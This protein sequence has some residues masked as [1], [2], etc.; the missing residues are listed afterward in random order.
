MTAA[1]RQPSA[2]IGL[3]V[4]CYT[5]V[6]LCAVALVG[7]LAGA[8]VALTGLGA[9]VRDL[10]DLAV[11]RESWQ[12]GSLPDVFLT[13]ARIAGAV[14][15]GAAMSPWLGR[16]C[17]RRLVDCFL[18]ALLIVNAALVGAAVSAYGRA[19]AVALL[20]HLALETF[21]F[22]LA[23]GAYLSSRDQSLRPP[24]LLTIGTTSFALLLLAAWVET[25][26]APGWL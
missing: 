13:N 19:L 2:R 8:A 7:A 21:A 1:V 18:G 5:A 12:A 9:G 4:L 20:P 6:A 17:A 23:T 24:L 14:L 15:I 26:A 22:A 10:L 16:S 25:R 11:H 3:R